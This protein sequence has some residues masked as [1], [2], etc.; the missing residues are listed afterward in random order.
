M[1]AIRITAF[2]CAILF[3]VESQSYIPRSQ[4]I[5]D[6]VAQSHGKGAYV[7]E[8]DVQFRTGADTV[9][10]RERWT[11]VDSDSMRVAVSL[12]AGKASGDNVHFEALYQSG[13]RTLTDPANG[14]IT[15]AALSPEFI[16]P[17]LHARSGRSFLNLLVRARII[18]ASLLN[19]RPRIQ[20]P[21]QANHA[22]EPLVW[23]GRTS[24]VVAWIFGEPSPVNG[25]ANPAVW[26]EQD[27]FLIRRLR[28]PSEAELFADNYSTYA[29]DL[30]FPRER[31]V[32]W[33]G[34]SV[35]IR[36]V[37]VRSLANNEAA[38]A[39]NSKTTPLKPGRLPDSPQIKEFY[40]RFR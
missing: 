7:I 2:L 16:E 29:R 4:T 23:L 25:P 36:V 21:E 28:F 35:H 39:L 19:E 22:P 24:G 13:K 31:T 15:T 26:I 1:R 37:S 27:A 6:R 20:K 30:K 8:Q 18:P 10:L 33:K 32:N 38:K 3:V 17:F 9:F 5:A 14:Q 12:P 11:I 34:G 40:T